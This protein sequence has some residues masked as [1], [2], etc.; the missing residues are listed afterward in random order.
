MRKVLLA[1]TLALVLSV[2]PDKPVF[3][4]ENTA[5]MATIRQF[6]DGFNRGDLNAAV[7][8]CADEASV[9]DDFP[10]HEWRG[11]GCKKWADAFE[12]L[13]KK[14]GITDAKISPDPPKHVDVND[15]RA[16]VVIPVTLVVNRGEKQKKL[17]S[18]F[19]AV[20]HREAGGWRITAWA[21]ADL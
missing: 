18:I 14:E 10:P 17:P 5:V 4:S 21:W 13:A 8:T 3:A 15:D 9:I 11:K 16:Y 6:F 12:A 19:T 7:A 1:L 2:L 20:L